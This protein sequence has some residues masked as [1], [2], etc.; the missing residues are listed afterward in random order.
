MVTKSRTKAI[1][2]PWKFAPWKISWPSKNSGLS[3][4]ELSSI[5]SLSCAWYRVSRTAPRIC[6][7][8]RSVY[9]FW[10]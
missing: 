10:R 9:A 7:T 8:A 2:W 3:L 6:G 5:S 4:A 1:G